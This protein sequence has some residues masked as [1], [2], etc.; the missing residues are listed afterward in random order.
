MEINILKVLDEMD[1]FRR[2]HQNEKV[3]P[4]DY[5]MRAMEAI[6]ASAAGYENRNEWTDALKSDNTSEYSKYVNF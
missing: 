2:E 6:V 3:S 1:R 4:S 5:C